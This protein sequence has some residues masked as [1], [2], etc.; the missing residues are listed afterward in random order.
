MFVSWRKH[1]NYKN[2]KNV[3]P[4]KLLTELQKYIEG[5]LLYIPHSTDRRRAWGERSGSKE[6][7]DLRNKEIISQ[8]NEGSSVVEIA[9]N[10]CLSEDTVRKIISSSKREPA[11]K[12][13]T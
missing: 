2:A 1:L 8:K 10:F 6:I 3:L 9:E 4:E 13:E 11:D 7:Y 12:K 5:E